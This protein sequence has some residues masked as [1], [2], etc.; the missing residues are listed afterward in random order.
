M[1]FMKHEV[2]CLH[3]FTGLHS[4]YHR[5]SD[6]AERVDA[7]GVAGVVDLCLE[8]VGR[9]QA[10]PALAYVDVPEEESAQ[11]S[12]SRSFRVRFG[13][14]PDYAY[15]GAG[16]RLTGTSPGSP[17]ERAGMIEGDVLIRVGDIEIDTIHDFV[18]CLQVHKPGDV[19]RATFLRDGVEEEVLVTLDSRE[20]E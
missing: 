19:V 15:Q 4:D 14:V 3:L 8:L 10:A 12:G 20:V 1:S 9:M 7:N 16:L 11:G 18:Y 5:P 2:P 6:D 13:T 17:A